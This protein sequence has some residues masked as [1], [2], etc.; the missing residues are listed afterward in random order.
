MLLLSMG[1]RYNELICYYLN[2]MRYYTLRR[3]YLPNLAHR[4]AIARYKHIKSRSLL[5][6][7]DRQS[8][9]EAPGVL[10]I[11]R[12]RDQV[13]SSCS[14]ERIETVGIQILQRGSIV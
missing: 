3:K 4:N 7:E 1:K 5:I 8:S 13:Y 2:S 10:K 14:R 9:K 11:P 12:Q 6:K